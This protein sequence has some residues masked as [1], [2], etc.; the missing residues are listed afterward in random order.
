MG[1]VSKMKEGTEGNSCGQTGMTKGKNT[2]SSKFMDDK[3]IYSFLPRGRTCLFS[4]G[5]KLCCDI[6]P[7]CIKHAVLT[8]EGRGIPS[9]RETHEQPTLAALHLLVGARPREGGRGSSR[10]LSFGLFTVTLRK[11]NKYLISIYLKSP[12][13][14]RIGVQHIT[15]INYTLILLS[16]RLW[17]KVKVNKCLT[18]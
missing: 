2:A 17:K 16:N 18:N 13:F 12:N 3:R 10:G 14:K 15:D 4:A 1:W 7:L 8:A 5:G 11:I 9:K 6:I